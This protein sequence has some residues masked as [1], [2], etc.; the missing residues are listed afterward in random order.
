MTHDEAGGE[1]V[2]VGFYILRSLLVFNHLYK[3][4]KEQGL[5]HSFIQQIIIE[6]QLTA[7]KCF[8]HWGYS[9]EQHNQGCYSRP[10]MQWDEQ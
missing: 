8:S 2:F 7:R 3:Y 5:Y 4:E 9:N 1:P 10:L 6:Y